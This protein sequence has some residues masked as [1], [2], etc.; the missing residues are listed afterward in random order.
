MLITRKQIAQQCNIT[1]SCLRPYL[2]RA[3][4]NKNRTQQ[5][6]LYDMEFEDIERLKSL[7]NSRSGASKRQKNYIRK[8]EEE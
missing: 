4:F 3:E 7:I 8:G 5:S 1:E 6:Y 2:H